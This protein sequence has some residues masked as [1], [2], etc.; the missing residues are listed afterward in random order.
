[1]LHQHRHHQCGIHAATQKCANRHITDHMK[2]QR[3]DQL[4]FEPVNQIVF[5]ARQLGLIVQI[6]VAGNLQTAV[7]SKHQPVRRRQFFDLPE[8]AARWRNDAQREILIQRLGVHFRQRRIKRQQRFY[9]GSKIKP[10]IPHHIIKRF[11]PE[12]VA[13]CKQALLFF[14]P[15]SECKH[16]AQ[17]ADTLLTHFLVQVQHHFRVAMCGKPVPARD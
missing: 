1:M 10:V 14:I 9:F 13:R 8:H 6:P 5:R 12:A 15:D 7:F 16:A 3:F 17:T 11:L 2:P 4:R